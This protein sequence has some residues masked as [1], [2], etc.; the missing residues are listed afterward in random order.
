VGLFLV[1]LVSMWGN[2]VV[3]QVGIIGRWWLS[4][5]CLLSMSKVTYL[6]VLQ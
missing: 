5:S 3:A 1:V 4:S 2:L 6:M